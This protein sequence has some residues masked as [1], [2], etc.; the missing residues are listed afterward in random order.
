MLCEFALRLE[1]AGLGERCDYELPMTQEQLADALGLT[2]VHTNRTLMALGDDGLIARNQ[3]AVRV[4]DRPGL[5]EVGDF[6][7]A[8]LQLNERGHPAYAR[9]REKP[10]LTEPPT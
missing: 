6:D 7:P 10:G 3:R 4:V 5:M 8:Y 9:A 2:S 1:T